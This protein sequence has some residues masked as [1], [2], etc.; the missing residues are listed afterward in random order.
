MKY[1]KKI[2]GKRL[3]LSPINLKDSETYTKWINDLEIS[4]NLGNAAGIYSIEKEKEALERINEEGYNF[5]LIDLKKDK[6]IGNCG[7]LNVNIQQRVAEL[8]IF[9]GN[10][11][12]WDKGYGKE[13][14]ELVLDYAFNILNLNN[15]MLKVYDFNKR[16]IKCYEKVGFKLI[17]KRRDAYQVGKKKY[18]EVY[19]D[20]LASEFEGNISIKESS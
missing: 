4:I 15:I 3:Y 8:G 19:M 20:I 14:I 13:G 9:I 5:A 7:L 12:Y 11:D 2:V 6:L 1:F 10:R 18:D 16:A 17:G